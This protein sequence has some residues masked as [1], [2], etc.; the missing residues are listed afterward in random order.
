M[1]V[2][3]PV[4]VHI[5]VISPFVFVPGNE[6]RAVNP[7][8]VEI[9]SHIISKIETNV[10]VFHLYLFLHH[11]F[12]LQLKNNFNFLVFLLVDNFGLFNFQRRFRAFDWFFKFFLRLFVM[13]VH[14]FVQFLYQKVLELRVFLAGVTFALVRN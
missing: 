6:H 10:L 12:S 14:N 3:G 7:K 4:L 2:S 9:A 5:E 1:I 11:R 13:F 8:I